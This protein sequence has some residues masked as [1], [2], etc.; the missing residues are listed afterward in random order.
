MAGE[1]GLSA[2]RYSRR[3]PRVPTDRE[4]RTLLAAADALIPDGASGS[5]PSA[6]ADYAAS[7]DR[8][9]AARGDAFDAVMTLVGA[10]ADVP[11]ED[12]GSELRRLAQEPDSGFQPLSAV[13]AGAYLMLPEVR[14]A[15]GYPGQAQRPPQFDEA[16]EEIMGG[17]LDP[18]IER[19]A[20]YRPVET[21]TLGEGS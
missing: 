21:A 10:L 6:F 12:L 19:G 13:V 3:P 16:A 14:R 11:A 17:I 9:L 15:I 8:A 2:P 7:L 18:V 4:R 20:I 1:S 5:R